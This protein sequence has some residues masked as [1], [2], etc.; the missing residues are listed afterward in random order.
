M[1][2]VTGGT[3]FL[4]RHLVEALRADGAAVRSLTRKP[5]TDPCAGVEYALGDLGDAAALRRALAG[6][7]RVYHVAGKIDFEAV[8]PA[9]MLAVN[10]DGARNVLQACFDAGVEKVVHVSSV[11][12]I[13]GAPDPRQPLDEEDFGRGTG[14]ELPYPYSKRL[15]E[16][17]ALAFADRGLPVT[18]VNPTFF[19]GPG[20]VNVTSA[21]TVVSFAR[22]Q[23]WIG[24]SR[25]GLG[26]TDVRDVAEGCV[27]A[28]ERGRPGRRYILGG[29]NLSLSEFH[30]LLGRILGRSAPR[31]R[32]PPSVAIG[33]A[34]FGV[35]WY[36]FIG[37][38]PFV[39]PGHV[40]M[41]MQHWYYNYRRAREELGLV[42]RPPEES[43]RDA[44]AWL[45]GAGL[46]S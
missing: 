7:R 43:L 11:S 30:A 18:I 37:R 34:H 14:V 13:G 2:L 29:T 22:G 12:T 1:I 5:P 28:M 25:G 35:R 20:D 16:E 42:C 26:Y 36:R 10:R 38:E 33:L 3:G 46:L 44:V 41:G 17:A 40:R 27:R 32:L 39:G 19:C 21:Q 31:L 6:V 9:E 24:L 23:V 8:D 4:G 15:G 45:R